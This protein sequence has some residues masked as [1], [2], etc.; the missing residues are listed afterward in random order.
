MNTLISKE[1]AMDKIMERADKVKKPSPYW[2]GLMFC[3]NV[4]N[5]MPSIY[6][7]AILEMGKTEKLIDR[8]QAIISVRDNPFYVYKLRRLPIIE[9]NCKIGQWI[10]HENADIIDGYYVPKYEC[11]CCHTWQ[12]DDSNFC[13]DCGTDMREREGKDKNNEYNTNNN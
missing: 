1:M 10:V 5:K 2:E 12:D 6:H 8:K 13:P 9:V 3:K 11:S 4:L 7:S